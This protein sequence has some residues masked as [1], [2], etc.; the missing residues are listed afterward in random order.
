[1]STR[2]VNAD[3]KGPK[4]LMELAT[5][6]NA[7]KELMDSK[8]AYLAKPNEETYQRHYT[9]ALDFADAHSNS[10][11]MADPEAAEETIRL[12][13]DRYAKGKAS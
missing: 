1:M 5:R 4:N 3:R 7:Y 2:E 13:K 6:A 8:A 9:A 10:E 11:G 12:M